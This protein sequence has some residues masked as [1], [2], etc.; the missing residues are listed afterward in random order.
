MNSMTLQKYCQRVGP[1]IRFFFNFFSLTFYVCQVVLL[2][3]KIFT[4]EKLLRL[5]NR[6]KSWRQSTGDVKMLRDFTD[7][8]RMILIM[9]PSS[10][11]AP[12][13]LPSSFLHVRLDTPYRST[14]AITSLARFVATSKGLKL[15]NSDFG[16]NVQGFKPIFF[17]IGKSE[18]TV[19]QLITVE[20]AI[21]YCK[22]HLGDDVTIPYGNRISPYIMKFIWEQSKEGGGSWDCYHAV[23]FFGWEAEKVIVVTDG[24]YLTEMITRAKMQ[25]RLTPDICYIHKR[26]YPQLCIDL[27]LDAF[28]AFFKYILHFL[29]APL[30]RVFILQKQPTPVS[31]VPLALL[32]HF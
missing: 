23:N 12:F 21:M 7:D 30:V 4:M 31:I 22:E 9:N 3:D 20:K 27:D 5:C 25:L 26:I 14:V 32:L 2:I 11:R 6:S 28:F 15:S 8:I 24:E 19:L 17:D 18:R 29:S 10:A 16:S 1:G 13:S